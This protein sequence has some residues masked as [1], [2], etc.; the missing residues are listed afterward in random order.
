MLQYRSL[1]RMVTCLRHSVSIRWRRIRKS[2]IVTEIRSSCPLV[3]HLPISLAYGH[4]R[5]RPLWYRPLWRQLLL[6]HTMTCTYWS[7]AT[8]SVSKRNW[9]ES[10]RKAECPVPGPKEKVAKVH[11]LFDHSIYCLEL[12]NFFVTMVMVLIEE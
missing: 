6:R 11:F 2:L 12:K 7:L 1:T 5:Y 8:S 9:S 10:S 4:H 3:R